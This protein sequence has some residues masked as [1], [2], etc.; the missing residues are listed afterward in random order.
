MNRTAPMAKAAA[1]DAA[2]NVLVVGVPHTDGSTA[3]LLFLQP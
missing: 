3:K 1:W 2:Q